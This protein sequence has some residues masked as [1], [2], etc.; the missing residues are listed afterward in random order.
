MTSI[1]QKRAG[2]TFDTD[3]EIG[4][5]NHDGIHTLIFLCRRIPDG[6]LKAQKRGRIEVWPTHWRLW[7][8]K[9]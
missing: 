1:L 5:K 7:Q 6:W 8:P 9:V 3:L 4:V 2:N